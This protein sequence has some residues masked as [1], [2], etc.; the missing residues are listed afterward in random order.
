MAVL[1]A[2]IGLYAAGIALLVVLPLACLPYTFNE[3]NLTTW[4][5]LACMRYFSFKMVYRATAT[6]FTKGKPYILVAPPHGVFPYGQPH[7]QPR[8]LA[9]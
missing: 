4:L 2:C 8:P 7:C 6:P 9:R 5:A 1:W 3:S